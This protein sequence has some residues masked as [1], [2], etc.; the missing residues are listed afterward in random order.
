MKF[1]DVNAN[2]SHCCHLNKLRDNC[3]KYFDII[4]IPR[5]PLSAV[6]Y[7]FSECLVCNTTPCVCW[8]SLIFPQQCLDQARRCAQRRSTKTKQ[9]G[10]REHVCRSRVQ[11]SHTGLREDSYLD[12]ERATFP[13]NELLWDE[14][15]MWAPQMTHD[16]VCICAGGS[17]DP[18]F[19]ASLPGTWGVVLG[20]PDK[21]TI[22]PSGVLLLGVKRASQMS[23]HC[24]SSNL[25]PQEFQRWAIG[26]RSWSAVLSHV[27]VCKTLIFQQILRSVVSV[28]LQNTVWDFNIGW[29]SFVSEF[30]SQACDFSVFRGQRDVHVSLASSWEEPGIVS[31][32]L[33]TSSRKSDLC[34]A[35]RRE[36]VIRNLYAPLISASDGVLTSPH[37]TASDNSLEGEEEERCSLKNPAETLS[38][39]K[40]MVIH[41]KSTDAQ[42]QRSECG[43]RPER[44]VR[45]CLRRLT[46]ALPLRLCRMSESAP[47][48]SNYKQTQMPQIPLSL[49]TVGWPPFPLCSGY[50]HP[51]SP[52]GQR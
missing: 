18:G 33:E 13:W 10:P 32:R 9:T 8:P 22:L 43:F 44:S 25:S 19:C 17:P 31:A 7:S 42:Q 15:L 50:L 30:K 52:S 34:N 11:L 21:P 1:Y 24:H 6:W 51:L 27:R 4:F 41:L 49:E 39:P 29:K 20:W 16:P 2:I 23:Q 35:A 47:N 5:S 14:S 46:S 3:Q 26:G 48:T 37:P 40:L 12:G 38:Y 36:A 28:L 45:R